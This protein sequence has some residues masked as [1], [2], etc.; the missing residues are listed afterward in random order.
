MHRE[1]PHLLIC[2]NYLSK[3]GKV[4]T[5]CGVT[6]VK[7]TLVRT[8]LNALSIPTK[9]GVRALYYIGNGRHVWRAK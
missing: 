6:I 7:T 8:I 2:G 5:I 9:T 3:S 1:G 4:G